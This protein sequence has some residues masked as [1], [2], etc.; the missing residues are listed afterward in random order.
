MLGHRGKLQCT[1]R[2]WEGTIP[3]RWLSCG[4]KSNQEEVTVPGR[5]WGT[6]LGEWCGFF[7]GGGM[8]SSRGKIAVLSCGEWCGVFLGG[9]GAIQQGEDAV[10]S[11]L[12]KQG[13]ILGVRGIQFQGEDLQSNEKALVQS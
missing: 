11:I 8:Q 2:G 1:I 9:G 6:L 4:T 5:S 13:T 10:L 12:R 7:L 3:G